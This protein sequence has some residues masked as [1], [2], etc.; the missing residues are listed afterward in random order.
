MIFNQGVPV[1]VAT[2]AAQ[3]TAKDM[4]LDCPSAEHKFHVVDLGALRN[5]DQ[6]EISFTQDYVHSSINNREY[7]MNCFRRFFWLRQL[8]KV[9]GLRHVLLA[10]ADMMFLGNV[11]RSYGLTDKLPFFALS[12]TSTYFSYWSLKI[13]DEFCSYIHNFYK[14]PKEEVFADIGRYGLVR[15]SAGH[16][17]AIGPKPSAEGWP[18]WMTPKQF[19]DMWIFTAFLDHR[20]DLQAHLK[21]PRVHPPEIWRPLEILH[22]LKSQSGIC[23]TLDN[24]SSQE[25]RWAEI[26]RER[27]RFLMPVVNGTQ[28]VALHFQ[29]DC[30]SSMVGAARRIGIG[31]P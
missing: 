19:S 20:P 3:T 21:F 30:K 4:R 23:Y 5:K 14:R 1:Y 2:D 27:Q 6:R 13:L 7:E 28:P 12:R 29:G 15:G 11:F 26:S 31:C 9:T 8:M 25:F 16:E 22:K 24:V 10:D 18:T 17:W